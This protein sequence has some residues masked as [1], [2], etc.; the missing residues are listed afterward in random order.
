M[1][2][3]SDNDFDRGLL[4]MPPLPDHLYGAIRREIRARARATRTVWAVAAS[5]VLMAGW[6]AVVSLPQ[7]N[8]LVSQSTADSTA[9]ETSLLEVYDYLNGNDIDQTFEQYAIVDP[10]FYLSE[11]GGTK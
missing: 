9:I 8:A 3:L 11:K 4:E 5:V 7:R 10:A 1:N 2:K 6:F